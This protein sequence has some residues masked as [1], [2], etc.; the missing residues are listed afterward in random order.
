MHALSSDTR[1]GTDRI[2]THGIDVPTPRL[3][4]RI[5]RVLGRI[6]G[7]TARQ[8]EELEVFTRTIMH[9]LEL[10]II[11]LAERGI[12]HLREGKSARTPSLGDELSVREYRQSRLIS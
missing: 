11:L 4:R 6:N 10:E 5:E 2:S 1:E 12:W 9:T 8:V 3:G 7:A